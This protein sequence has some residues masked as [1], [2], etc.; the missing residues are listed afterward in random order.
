MSHVIL[1]NSSIDGM[2]YTILHAEAC[3]V[4]TERVDGKARMGDSIWIFFPVSSGLT[5][6]S[7]RN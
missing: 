3:P 5:M 1:L 2:D 7:S 4:P 6:Y